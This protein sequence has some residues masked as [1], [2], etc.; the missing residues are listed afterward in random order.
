MGNLPDFSFRTGDYAFSVV[1]TPTVGQPSA[2][3]GRVFYYP[4]IEAALAA[5]HE[6]PPFVRLSTSG[7]GNPQANAPA[8]R[9]W[10]Q[11]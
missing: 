3:G 11:G 5:G 1:T 7:W 10:A 2:F 4:T 6:E 8:A 9:D